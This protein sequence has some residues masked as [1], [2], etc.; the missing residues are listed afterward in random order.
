MANLTMQK[1][2]AL[3][4]DELIQTYPY[5]SSCRQQI[6][7]A[8]DALRICFRKDG[9]L[10]IAGNG[11]SASDSSHIVGELMKGFLC[12]RPLSPSQKTGFSGF[13]EGQQLAGKLQQALPAIALTEQSALLSA[14]ANDISSD[15]VYAQQVFGYGRPGD[16]FMGL[17]TSGNSENIVLAARTASACGLKTIAITGSADSRLSVFCDICIRVPFTATYQIQEGTLPV[18]HALC[19]MLEADFFG[20][21]ND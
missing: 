8:Y 5:L 14:I 6:A 7:A 17:S 13:S 1:T 15:M 16:V 9:K 4:L 20:K 19:A 3:L 10:L 12:T 2:P 11:G 18:Y 21:E